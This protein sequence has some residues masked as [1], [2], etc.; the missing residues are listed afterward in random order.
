MYQPPPEGVCVDENNQPFDCS[1]D[2]DYASYN[3]LDDGCDTEAHQDFRDAL[4]PYGS[5][6]GTAEYGQVW[7]PSTAVVGADFTP[8]YSGGR[9]NYTDYGWTWVSDYHR[10][11]APF[12]YGRWHV[13]GNYGW[14][15]IPGRVWGPAWVHWRAGG[16]YVGWRRCRRVA[17]A[18]RLRFWGALAFVELCSTGPDQCAAAG[19]RRA[20]DAAYALRTHSASQ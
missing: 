12:H 5:W 8:Y 6:V 7:V 20:A 17:F 11:W 19:S 16:G 14:C 10:G 18:S 9:W 2:A 4:S 15:W 13:I 1:Q 3:Q